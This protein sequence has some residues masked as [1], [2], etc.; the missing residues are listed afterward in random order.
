MMI[1]DVSQI[2]NP[3]KEREYIEFR[4]RSMVYCSFSNI[5]GS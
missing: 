5:K 2:I 1:Y 4:K 3:I